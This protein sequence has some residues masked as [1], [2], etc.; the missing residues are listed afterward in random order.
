MFSVD[1]EELM[2]DNNMNEILEIKSKGYDFNFTDQ[3]GA[4][5]LHYAAMHNVSLEIVKILIE[6]VSDLNQ[7]DKLGYTALHYASFRGYLEIAKILIDFGANYHLKNDKG[8]KPLVLAMNNENYDLVS[9]LIGLELKEKE[10]KSKYIPVFFNQ[11]IK[12]QKKLSTIMLIKKEK[13]KDFIKL[14]EKHNSLNNLSL[15]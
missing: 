1:I 13:R 9:Y 2:I 8:H 6:L 5:V 4:N 11:I 15:I 7:K 10:K 3:S 14:L 12:K